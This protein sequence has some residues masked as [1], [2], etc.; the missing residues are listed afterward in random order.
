MI[1]QIVFDIGNVMSDFQWKKVIDSLAISQDAKDALAQRVFLGP[2][3]EEYDRGVMGDECVTAAL[4]KN[5]AGYE[6]EFE[7]LYEHYTDLVVE[8]A[9]AE[10]LVRDLKAGGYGVY[11]LSNYGDTMYRLNGQYFKF[12]KLVD[13]AVFSWQEKLI[14]PNPAIYQLLLQR[15][16][17]LP[18][19][20]LFLDDRA[21][22]VESAR[23]EGIMAETAD[24][25][26]KILAAFEKHGVRI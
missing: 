18:E 25:Y 26:E 10:N 16:S 12:L 9:Y 20:T 19:E 14:K 23:N 21:D 1:R 22:N 5:C 6:A 3:W 4:R 17:F 8:R 2:L 7:L 13:G 11:V 24:S 15:F